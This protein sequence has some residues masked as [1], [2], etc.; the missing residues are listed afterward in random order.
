VAQRTLTPVSHAHWDREWYQPSEE[1][2]IC[3]V[4]LMD[5]LLDILDRDPDFRYVMLDG[6]AIVLEDYLAIRPEREPDVAAHVRSGRLL[7]G[8]WYI[9]PDE[10]LVSPESNIRNLLT[11]A[12]VASRFG[13]RMDVGNIPD[14]FGHISQLPQILRGS[15]MDCAVFWRGVG[16][17]P[18]EFLWAAPDGSDV[19]VIHTPMRAV[20]TGLREGTLEESSAFVRVEPAALVITA[21]KEAEDGRGLIVRLWNSSSARCEGEVRLWRPAAQVT[22][23]SLDET[24]IELLE[25]AGN[26]VVRL[27]ARGNEV[28]TLR[29]AFR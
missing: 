7:I 19:L 23:C 15:G 11:G 27:A 10:F 25:L 29:V 20:S 4:R 28:V 26:Q 5:R 14:P 18:N 1:F 3:L 13:K 21:L 2:R 16:D 8:P 12:R 9:L 6:Q 24:E 17:A 22:R